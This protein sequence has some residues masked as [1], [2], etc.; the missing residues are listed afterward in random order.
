MLLS[1]SQKFAVGVACRVL[2][3]WGVLASAKPIVEQMLWGSVGSL[4]S[5]GLIGSAAGVPAA[6]RVARRN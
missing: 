5:H 3:V 4:R 1:I 6:E 2:S